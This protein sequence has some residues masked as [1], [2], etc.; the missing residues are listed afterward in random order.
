M[1]TH[2]KINLN[3]DLLERWHKSMKD[4][5]MLTTDAHKPD[6]ESIGLD[7][8]SAE[9]TEKRVAADFNRTT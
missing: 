3:T 1:T 6:P 2:E 7:A 9:R 5:P 8:W 4:H